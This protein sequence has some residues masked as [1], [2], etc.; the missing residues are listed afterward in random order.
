MRCH[1]AKKVP[2]VGAGRVSH[3]GRTGRVD[4]CTAYCSL[5]DPHST[6]RPSS[7]YFRDR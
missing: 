3:V 4:R 6:Y 2:W 7:L 5:P 1:M